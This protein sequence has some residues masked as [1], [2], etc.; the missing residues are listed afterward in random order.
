MNK[1]VGNPNFET[2]LQT[3]LSD[4]QLTEQLIKN[5]AEEDLLLTCKCLVY[6][7]CVINTSSYNIY[8]AVSIVTPMLSG[9]DFARKFFSSWNESV[10]K[11]GLIKSP[12]DIFMI[13]IISGEKVT[14]A[15]KKGFAEAIE[16]FNTDQLI[17]SQDFLSRIIKLVHPNPEKSGAIVEINGEEFYTL[18]LISKGI[19]LTS[20]TALYNV[21]DKVQSTLTI[22]EHLEQVKKLTL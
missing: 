18:S 22:K 8:K 15:M 14:N 10:K 17:Q 4:N 19:K 7:H 21:K 3:L 20:N 9:T 2:F 5:C 13:F 6:A 12:L 11:G 16:S 1:N